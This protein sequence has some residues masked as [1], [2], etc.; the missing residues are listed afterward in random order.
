[1]WY[2][3][4]GGAALGSEG[5][6]WDGWRRARIKALP[7]LPVAPVTRIFFLIMKAGKNQLLSC[8]ARGFKLTGQGDGRRTVD[9]AQKK[10]EAKN[11]AKA[12]E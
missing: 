7:C 12:W 5:G 2:S 11:K 6:G 1:M 9:L 4:E 3:D 10:E 8:V